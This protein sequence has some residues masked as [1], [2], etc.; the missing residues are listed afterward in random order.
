MKIHEEL[1]SNFL[2]LRG[3]GAN[4]RSL[5]ARAPATRG[6]FAYLREAH[7]EGLGLKALRGWLAVAGGRAEAEL[8]GYLSSRRWS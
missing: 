6:Y 3:L 2:A 7:S 1:L 4:S 8:P 5:G